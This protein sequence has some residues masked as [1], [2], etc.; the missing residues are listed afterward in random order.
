MR[1]RR[2]SLLFL[3]YVIIG[4]V[5]A[6]NRDYITQDLLLDFL[7]AILLVLLWPLVLLGVISFDF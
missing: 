4:V 2:Y 5:V 7:K 3:I 1:A 6:L